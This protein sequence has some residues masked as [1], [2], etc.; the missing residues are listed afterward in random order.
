MHISVN[1]TLDIAF[2][3]IMGNIFTTSITMNSTMI[4]L[5]NIYTEYYTECGDITGI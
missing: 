2:S 4:L 3:V 5:F 1:I